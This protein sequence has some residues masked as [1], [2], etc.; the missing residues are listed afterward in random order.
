MNICNINTRALLQGSFSLVRIGLDKA[1]SQLWTPQTPEADRTTIRVPEGCVFDL[2]KEKEQ[3]QQPARPS[4]A[5]LDHH[6][7]ESIDD[8]RDTHLHPHSQLAFHS[9]TLNKHTSI[10][11]LQMRTRSCKVIYLSH[12]YQN[13]NKRVDFEFIHLHFCSPSPSPLPVPRFPSSFSCRGYLLS[14]VSWSRL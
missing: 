12:S 2:L 8:T 6:D 11:H 1:F 3:Y 14:F 5:V 4:L 7:L 10:R 13:P 9:Y